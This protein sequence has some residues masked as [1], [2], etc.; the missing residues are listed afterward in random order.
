MRILI[1]LFLLFF[2]TSSFSNEA[3][4]SWQCR[5]SQ[6]SDDSE[7]IVKADILKGRETGNIYVAGVRLDTS[8]SMRGFN[9]RWDFKDA[10][11]IVEAYSYAFII[12]PNGVGEYYEFSE[13][14]KYLP[15]MYLY[16]K[17]E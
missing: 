7:I 6:L 2:S 1:T 16:C 3:F 4:E 11:S 10:E 8:F 15:S 17:L 5:G 13:L 9:R 14:G 12:N